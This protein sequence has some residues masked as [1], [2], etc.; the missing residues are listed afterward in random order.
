MSKMAAILV[1]AASSQKPVCILLI[2]TPQDK[3]PLKDYCQRRC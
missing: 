1:A 2:Y 3:T